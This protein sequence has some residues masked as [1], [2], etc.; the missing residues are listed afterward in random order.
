MTGPPGSARRPSTCLAN[1]FS[2]FVEPNADGFQFAH[3][4]GLKAEL[5][6]YLETIEPGPLFADYLRS[7]SREAGNAVG[8][9][10]EPNAA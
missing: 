5:A 4:D 9:L 7:I 8:L 10:V 2:F 6:P 3:P 1:S